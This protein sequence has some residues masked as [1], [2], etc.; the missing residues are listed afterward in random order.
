MRAPKFS[1]FFFSHYVTT[2]SHITVHK[3]RGTICFLK[4]PLAEFTHQCLKNSK[5]SIFGHDIFYSN[6]SM[7]KCII[8]WTVGGCDPK[9]CLSNKVT[10]FNICSQ[11]S[12]IRQNS[13]TMSVYL[14]MFWSKL[15]LIIFILLSFLPSLFDVCI[16]KPHP[17]Y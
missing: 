8:S 9:S 10:I 16:L 12:E 14:E 15:H 13:W 7:K 17:T 5:K 6:G 4:A 11:H 2:S 3:P 1:I